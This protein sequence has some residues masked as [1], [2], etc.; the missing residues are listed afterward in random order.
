M[1]IVITKKQCTSMLCTLYRVSYGQ[2][3]NN[4][5]VYFVLPVVT[6]FP[7]ILACFLS[8]KKVATVYLT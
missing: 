2:K 7:H 8:L 6:P 4:R 3:S 5:L 1:K